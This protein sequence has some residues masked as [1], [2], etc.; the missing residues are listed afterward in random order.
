MQ[1]SEAPCTNVCSENR[2]NE[3]EWRSPEENTLYVRMQ[4]EQLRGRSV[5][6]GTP[7]A[8]HFSRASTRIRVLYDFL[9]YRHNFKA[10]GAAQGNN[11]NA[12][13]LE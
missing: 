12:T 10:L 1:R 6:D 11:L 7:V 5:F 3:K 4:F 13:N 2:Q 8:L 9:R